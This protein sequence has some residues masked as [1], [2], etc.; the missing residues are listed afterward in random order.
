MKSFYQFAALTLSVTFLL[1]GGCS[2]T[3]NEN[4]G[5][6]LVSTIKTVKVYDTDTYDWKDNRSFAYNIAHMAQP[7]GAGNGLSDS[8]NPTNGVQSSGTN[9][10]A[11]AFARGFLAMDAL[12][13][14][15]HVFLSSKEKDMLDYGPFAVSFVGVNDIDLNDEVATANYLLNTLD[16]ELRS[17]TQNSQMDGKFHGVYA[18]AIK[19]SKRNYVAVLEGNVCQNGANFLAPEE[20][21]NASFKN[22]K[23]KNYVLGLEKELKDA[24]YSEVCAIFYES[25]VAGKLGNKYIVVHEAIN[26]NLA[27]YYHNGIAPTSTMAF[28]FP[29]NFSHI[30]EATR[31][32]YVY[33]FPY[34]FVS[35]KGKQYLFDANEDS[36]I[37]L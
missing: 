32:K 10:G 30:N 28:V 16:T 34:S 29:E 17:A 20:V 4:K 14:I 35:Y 11:L 36:K 9:T 12:T 25:S 18:N 21:K 23:L 22:T 26:S 6:T 2:S 27:L 1:L 24:P 37:T 5:P 33:Q 8:Y 31:A 15:S 19:Y 13:G 7:S 3:S